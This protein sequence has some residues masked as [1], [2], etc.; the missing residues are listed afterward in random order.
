MTAAFRS[1]I[2][3]V[4]IAS[5]GM[6]LA[7]PA[8]AADWAVPPA[9]PRLFIGF[10]DLAAMRV[11]CGA[12]RAGEAGPVATTRSRFA[13]HAEA[14]ERLKSVGA[15]I[16]KDRAR[17]DDLFVPAVLHLATGELGRADAYTAFVAKELL[18][19]DRGSPKNPYGLDDIVALDY[20]WD[21]IPSAERSKMI[22]RAAREMELLDAN[23]SPLD[24]PTFSRALNSLAAAI[25]ISGPEAE[26][27]AEISTRLRTVLSLAR[28]YFEG[29]YSAFCRQRGTVPTSGESGIWEEADLVLAAELWRSL[30]GAGIYDELAPTLGRSLEHYY[31]ADTETPTL[32]HGFVHDDGS[33]IPATPGQLYRGFVPAVSW[34]LARYMHNPMAAWYADRSLPITGPA[35]YEADRYGWVRLVY[36]P[37]DCPE[38]ERAKCPLGRNLGGGWVTMRSDWQP[39]AS[40]LL[41]DVGQPYW[42]SRQ[43][44]DAGQFQIYR[45]GRLAIDSGDDVTRDAVAG[46]G[47]SCTI[48]GE[49]GDW[50]LYAQATIAHNCITVLD[51]MQQ[52]KLYG[53]PWPALGNQRLIED[54]YDPRTLDIAKSTRATGRL[55]AFETN[56]HYSY[57]A[58]D[59][60]PAYLPAVVRSIGREVLFLNSGAVVVLDRVSSAK[61]KFEKAW[62]LQL[63]SRPG[64]LG[65]PTPAAEQNAAAPTKRRPFRQIR[66]SDDSAG[67]WELEP[68]AEWVDVTDGGGKLFVRTLLP[69][70]AQR[71][72]AGGPMQPGQIRS[73]TMSGKPYF[74]GDPLG[75]EHRLWPA[76]MLRAPN[77]AYELGNPTSLG[78]DFGV[79]ATWGRLDV[80]P[81]DPETDSVFLNVLIPTNADVPSP[82]AVKFEQREGRG[83]LRIDLPD[84][85]AE[86]DL[87]ITGDAPS[88][89]TLR[90]PATGKV[91]VEKELT[92]TVE[93]NA[94]IPVVSAPMTA[95]NAPI[96]AGAQ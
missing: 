85:R 8:F 27:K 94:A 32:N 53:R 68:A 21:A 17:S 74:G 15:D 24:H 63:P 65:T 59:L 37:L 14:L 89:I 20:C 25:V 45:R 19:P 48:G 71:R 23:Q 16:L 26:S 12:T 67:V 5:M 39:G 31:Y 22:D 87:R 50:D 54:N 36:G 81:A 88:R 10:K 64:L 78:P 1:S 3:F 29:P 93:P 2:R 90:H 75:Y 70:G 43:H 52:M 69:L 57:A 62:H 83:L 61:P 44:F 72:L 7:A 11:Q 30:A 96:P 34:V 86:L 49:P 77:A 82:P 33:R 84:A 18:D 47:G 60:S 28:R 13:V 40:L 92:T 42:R 76:S 66:G 58:A 79:G 6:V 51:T 95:G 73:G 91:L 38:P 46:K 4:L 55:V 9:H 56:A 80:L 41:F 35:S